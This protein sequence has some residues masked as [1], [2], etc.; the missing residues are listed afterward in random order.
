MLMK[1]HS[2]RRRTQAMEAMFQVNK[3][4]RQVQVQ[5]EAY[6]PA[7]I[8]SSPPRLSSPARSPHP[9]SA[10]WS[11]GKYRGTSPSGGGFLALRLA[12]P[13]D[14]AAPA[15]PATPAVSWDSLRV[16]G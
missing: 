3:L 1:I 2:Q 7:L 14:S 13:G 4:T 9:G 10:R 8:T 16:T 12:C 11:R 15:A 5:A 6:L